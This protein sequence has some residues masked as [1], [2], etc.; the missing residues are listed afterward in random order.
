MLGLARV[1]AGDNEMRGWRHGRRES[2]RYCYIAPMVFVVALFPIYR[3]SSI[4][5]HSR[6]ARPV[7][8]FDAVRRGAF[9]CVAVADSAFHPGVGPWLA[10][11][12]N[13]Q[14]RRADCR[15]RTV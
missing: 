12:R 10:G 2:G 7:C 11:Q 8:G 13:A 15:T 1:R 5:P 3:W 6:M 4:E 9:V 14:P